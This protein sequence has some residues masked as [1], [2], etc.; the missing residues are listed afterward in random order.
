MS[1][2]IMRQ[3]TLF[4]FGMTIEGQTTLLDFGLELEEE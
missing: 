2:I 4:E 1:K 3:T